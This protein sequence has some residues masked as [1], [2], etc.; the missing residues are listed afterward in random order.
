MRKTLRALC[1]ISCLL[2]VVVWS[3]NSSSTEAGAYARKSVTYINALWLMDESVRGLRP[4]QVGYILD[5]VKQGISMPRFDYNP[6]PDSLLREFTSQANA[7]RYPYV[8]EAIATA[9][10]ADPMLDSISAVMERTVVP[11]I[12]EIVDLNKEMRAA[13]LTTEE[14]RNSFI[15]DKAKTMGITMDD[16]R[17]VINS[18]YIY[19]P[20]IRGYSA[21]LKDS[22][23]SVGFAAG[24]VWFRIVNKGDKAR[25]VPVMKNFTFSSGFS[26]R[27]R[28]YAGDGG[29]VD[30]R[31]FAFQSAVRNAAR[32]LVVATQQIPEFRLSG[33]VID[34]GIMSVG[35]NLGKRE[36]IKLDD[37]YQIVEISEDEKGNQTAK[38]SGWV[39][40]TSVADSNSKQGYKSKA[41]VIGGNP[42]VGAV[43]SEYPRLPVDLQIGARM[44]AYTATADT[45]D[46][47]ISR[48]KL[49]NGFGAGIDILYDI[50]K[51]LCLNQFFFAISGGIGTGSVSGYKDSLYDPANDVE[52][53]GANISG[54]LSWNAEV[55]LVKKFYIGRVA[56]VLQPEIGYQSI[57]LTT[58]KWSGPNGDEYYMLNN[59][60]LGFAGNGALEFAVSPSIN[61]GVGAG[62][63]LYGK[64]SS[65]DYSYKNG[66]NG[67]WQ[68]IA[69]VNS[70]A[71]VDHTGVTARA[72]LVWS[73]PSLAFD[74]LDM[75][76]GM[77]GGVK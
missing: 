37:K 26:I 15:A 29:M 52:H 21:Q 66:S 20:L 43:L 53:G 45:A 12:L 32:N 58:D 65:W 49:S 46:S 14:Q 70:G 47:L 19:L 76:H 17:K 18:A 36:G 35:F 23:Y 33:Q 73:L 41:Q 34:K 22:S 77:A 9:G 62:Y 57:I 38:K 54:L 4:P 69:T 67:N 74:P 13:N 71:G 1:L 10:G 24:I 72:Y 40:V 64:S 28:H 6:V 63:Q 50:G 55:S 2:P 60:A 56:I 11:K 30:Y 8:N 51:W 16:I 39:M 48:L 3:Q 44:F 59:T 68:K 61:L 5:K 42:Y 75:L 7:V 25:A 31:E 27:D